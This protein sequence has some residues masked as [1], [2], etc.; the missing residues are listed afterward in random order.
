MSTQSAGA[1]VCV[2]R[3]SRDYAPEVHRLTYVTGS[4]PGPLASRSPL[5]RFGKQ[6]RETIDVWKTSRSAGTMA[7]RVPPA[8]NSKPNN[9]TI[10]YLVGPIKLVLYRRRFAHSPNHSQFAHV[11]IALE[12]FSVYPMEGT[13]LCDL[14]CCTPCVSLHMDFVDPGSGCPPKPSQF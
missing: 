13:F 14:D 7:V 3:T 2:L 9:R 11:R 8:L 6:P 1:V 12:G 4:V 10:V 5:H